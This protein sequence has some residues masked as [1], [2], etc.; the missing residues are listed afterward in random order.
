MFDF[1]RKRKSRK[2]LEKRIQQLEIENEL[3]LFH[4]KYTIFDVEATRRERNY[5]SDIIRN[6]RG[7]N[8]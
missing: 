1:L 6:N 5:L 2:Q 8:I 3:L 7:D 4:L